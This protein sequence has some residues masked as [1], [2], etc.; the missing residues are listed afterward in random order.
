MSAPLLVASAPSDGELA[1]RMEFPHMA[2]LGYGPDANDLAW[3]CGGSLIS[4]NWVLTAAHCLSTRRYVFGRSSLPSKAVTR[5]L[6][7]ASQLE[8]RFTPCGVGIA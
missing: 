4:A 8:Y 3:L 6:C 1:D 5:N 7:T 2:L